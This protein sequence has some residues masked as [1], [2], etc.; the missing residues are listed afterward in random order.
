MRRL[1]RVIQ[2]LRID[3][4]LPWISPG[5]RV[6]DVGCADGALFRRARHLREGVGIDPD[7]QTDAQGLAATLLRGAFP[8]DLPECA[9]FDVITMLAVLEHVP[10][11]RQSALATACAR[12]LRPGGHL[13]ITVPSPRV[14]TILSVLRAMRLL[15]GMSLEEHYGFN[16][17]S[18]PS[19]FIPHGFAVV[20]HRRFQFGLNNLFV[21]R[22]QAA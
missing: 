5:D 12:C 10:R 18:T 13:V 16:P 7:L 17:R 8:E 6:L 1:D 20:A 22:K 9:P 21:F 14:D 4:A 15:D 2:R 3:Q 19:I 11:D